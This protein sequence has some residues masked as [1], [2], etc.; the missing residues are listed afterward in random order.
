MSDK[1][2]EFRD[3]EKKRSTNLRFFLSLILIAINIAVILFIV[4]LVFSRLGDFGPYLK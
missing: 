2:N 3:K 1:D 4:K